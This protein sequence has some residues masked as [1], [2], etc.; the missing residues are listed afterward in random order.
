MDYESYREGLNMGYDSRS[1]W[2]IQHEFFKWLETL[3]ELRKVSFSVPNEKGSRTI[4]QMRNLKMSGLTAGAPDVCICYPRGKYHGLFIEFKSSVG[5]LSDVQRI[6]L[7]NLA[8]N[9]YR[10]LVCWSAGEAIN[11]VIDYCNQVNQPVEQ[12]T[13]MEIGKRKRNKRIVANIDMPIKT[14]KRRTKYS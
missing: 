14:R 10:C 2:Y 7:T 8:E 3:P 1:E 4:G 12:P 6:M 9:G 13:A 11:A 5:R